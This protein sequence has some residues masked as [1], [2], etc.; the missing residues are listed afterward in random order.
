[1]PYIVGMARMIWVAGT[2]EPIERDHDRSILSAID[3]WGPSHRF[4]AVDDPTFN[5]APALGAIANKY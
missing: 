4:F 3:L 5:L 2:P 1:M